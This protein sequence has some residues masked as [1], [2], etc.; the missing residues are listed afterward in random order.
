[1]GTRTVRVTPSGVGCGV[2]VAVGVC[3]RV[4]RR[5]RVGD[6]L[7]VALAVDVCVRVAEGVDVVVGVCVRV[8][9]AVGV[10]VCVGVE[11]GVKVAVA[12]EVAVGVANHIQKPCCPGGS[13]G[14]ALAGRPATPLPRAKATAAT[15]HTS[16]TSSPARR[17]IVFRDLLPPATM[18][19]TGR[20]KRLWGETCSFTSM[21]L[22]IDHLMRSAMSLEWQ[23]QVW[24]VSPLYGTFRRPARQ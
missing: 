23:P 2:G 24:C 15:T 19:C 9:V 13:K 21:A 6:A 10:L 4:G 11:V 18:R 1:M 17:R 5:V 7:G 8:A 12:D 14:I 22:C 3:V 20:I 16:P